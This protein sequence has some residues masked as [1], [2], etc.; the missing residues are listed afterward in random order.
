MD[1]IDEELARL[2]NRLNDL[3]GKIIPNLESQSELLYARILPLK[4]DS[5]ERRKLEAEYKLLSK[6]LSKR[7]NEL[8]RINQ[9]RE[10]LELEKTLGRR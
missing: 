3:K 10:N 2:K 9:D 7:S 6:E 8:I 4:K 5:D 1:M